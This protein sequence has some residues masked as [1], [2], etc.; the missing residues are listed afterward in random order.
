M[1]TILVTG[2]AGF[3]GSHVCDALLARGKKVVCIDN[4]NDYY[5]PR[6]KEKNI[7]NASKNRNFGLYRADITDYDALR[8]VF[9]ENKVDKIIHLAA[10]AGVR[11]SFDEPELYKKVNVEGT[12]NLLELAK[13]FKIKNFVFG[14]SSSVYGTNKKIPFSEN[15]PT[16]NAISPYAETKKKAEELCKQYHDKLGL[17]IACLRFFTVYGP[18]GR[19]DMAVYKFIELISESKPIDVYGDGTSK[20]DY[21]YVADIVDGALSALDKNFGFEVINLGNSDAVELKKLIAAI[22][23]ELGKKAKINRLPMQKGDVHLT[24]ANISKAR[25]LLDYNP[26]IK[27]GEG[28]KLFAEW[29]K[30]DR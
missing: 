6:I 30:N 15:D 9:I 14:S 13:E 24:Y 22:E 18:R 12:R 10:R 8:N 27:I 21:T 19:P 17:S 23:K 1:E 3:I 29:Y 28:I 7:E 20:R 5:D 11:S 25:K 26:K 16:E 2:G 4:F